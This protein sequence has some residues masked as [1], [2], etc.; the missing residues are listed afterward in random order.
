MTARRL[1]LPERPLVK[2]GAMGVRQG[3]VACV[4][5]GME[6]ELIVSHFEC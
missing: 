4:T 6:V 5:L 1:C 3:Q 2:A